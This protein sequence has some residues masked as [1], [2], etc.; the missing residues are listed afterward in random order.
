[1][2]D[3]V[4]YNGRRYVNDKRFMVIRDTIEAFE[5]FYR[6]LSGGRSWDDISAVY[7]RIPGICERFVDSD[8]P[9][10]SDTQIHMWKLS[11]LASTV[12]S[13]DREKRWY[14][15]QEIRFTADLLIEESK[16]C[17]YRN[18]LSNAVI[19][20]YHIIRPEIIDVYMG[21]RYR[22]NLLSRSALRSAEREMRKEK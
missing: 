14:V 21:T 8:I 18:A 2:T 16:Y 10:F 11:D 17:R 7:G 20:A 6:I 13:D 19:Q 12:P 1:M 4:T 22:P 9:M 15:M 3:I 5:G